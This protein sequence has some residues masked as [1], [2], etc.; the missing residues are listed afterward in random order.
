MVIR[1]SLSCIKNYATPLKTSRYRK[2]SYPLKPFHANQSPLYLGVGRVLQVVNG[3]D[4]SEVLLYQQFRGCLNP[5]LVDQLLRHRG[6]R[7]LPTRHRIR[8]AILQGELLRHDLDAIEMCCFVECV[9]FRDGDRY[10]FYRYPKKYRYLPIPIP[11]LCILVQPKK[12]KR[13]LPTP[14]PHL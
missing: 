1:Y 6:N 12:K 4:L 2:Q 9:S 13:Y 5:Q 10:Y 8:L 11:I 7:L 3:S 14:I